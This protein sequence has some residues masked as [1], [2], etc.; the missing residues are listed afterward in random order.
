MS[1]DSRQ[2]FA[3]G[4]YGNR[5]VRETLSDLLISLIVRPDAIWLVSPWVSDFDLLDN[6][7]NGWTSINPAWG[8]RFVR[9]SELLAAAVDAGSN[10]R[11]VT[12]AEPMN[13]RFLEQIRSSL[14]PNSSISRCESE[15]LHTKGLLC[16][17]FFLSGSMNFTYS[18]THRNDENIV[19]TTDPNVIAEARIEFESKYSI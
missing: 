11:L 16:S 5:Q 9:F 3:H 13:G 15:T 19:L 8:A 10:L 7:S 4:P 18:G 12:N 17:S 1:S 2:I 6:R 14:A